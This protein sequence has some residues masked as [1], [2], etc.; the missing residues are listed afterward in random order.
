MENITNST[1]ELQQVSDV[2]I[3]KETIDPIKE[4]EQAQKAESRYVNIISQQSTSKELNATKESSSLVNK[5]PPSQPPKKRQRAK[6]V[7][8]AKKE[9]GKRVSELWGHF[10]KLEGSN[11]PRAACNYCGTSYAAHPKNDGTSTMWTHLLSLCKSYPYRVEKSQKTMDDYTGDL[12]MATMAIRMK[13]KFNKYWGNIENINWLLFVATLVDPRY[14]LKY[15]T[16]GFT[17]IYEGDSYF[18]TR[19]TE[20]IESI[21]GLLYKHYG[22]SN[23][24]QSSKENCGSQT[25]NYMQSDGED[26]LSELLDSQFAKHLEEEQC[27]ESKSE[28]ARYLLDGCEKSSKDFDVLNWWKVNTPKYPV[29]SKV[30]R[31]VLAIPVSTIA[32]ESAFSTSGRVIDPFRSS[33]S[34]KMVEALICAQDWLR[35]TPPIDLQA[36][37]EDIEQFEEFEKELEG[38]SSLLTSDTNDMDD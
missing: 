8:I 4:Q 38:S 3:L 7:E 20:K 6:A 33:L 14:K 10:T 5:K 26:D 28:L 30:A 27:V 17:T 9:E 23:F 35:A 15:V 18:V 25:S 16:F 31:D 13:E 2:E 24:Q 34:P 32:S 12:H 21:V 11:P 29:L 37:I 1:K 19:M 36:V 22:D